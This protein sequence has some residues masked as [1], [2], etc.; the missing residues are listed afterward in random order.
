MFSSKRLGKLKN[1]FRNGNS[2]KKW[3]QN[4]NYERY[5]KFYLLG[6]APLITVALKKIGEDG[7]YNLIF[8]AQTVN[9]SANWGVPTV[10]MIA[11][12]LFING[13]KTGKGWT[14]NIIPKRHYGNPIIIRF[15]LPLKKDDLIEIR[16][17]S[18]STK[19]FPDESVF[20]LMDWD[21]LGHLRRGRG[22]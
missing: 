6:Q 22:T 13:Q 17:R 15:G 21:R 7:N 19:L 14:E 1:L 4:V 10:V 8:S 3:P 16:M 11:A 9:N 20:V 2:P 12:K 18:D 5:E